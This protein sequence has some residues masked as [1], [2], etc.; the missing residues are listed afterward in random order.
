MSIVSHV[1]PSC[2]GV[3]IKTVKGPEKEYPIALSV[4]F[5]G[6]K[7]NLLSPRRPFSDGP[8]VVLSGEIVPEPCF[9]VIFDHFVHF[10]F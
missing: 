5:M 4:V 6:H 8:K 3:R 1:E 9:S 7:G 2:S 10:I